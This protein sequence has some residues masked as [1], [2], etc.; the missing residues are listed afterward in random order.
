MTVF[1]PLSQLEPID[2]LDDLGMF[3]DWTVTVNNR[4]PTDVQEARVII[5]FP[6]QSEVTG[7]DYF[8]YPGSITSRGSPQ[9]Q[10]VRKI[11]CA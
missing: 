4:G 10:T 8:L 3:R 1:S 9:S 7:D 11:L 2:S 5:Y 6:S